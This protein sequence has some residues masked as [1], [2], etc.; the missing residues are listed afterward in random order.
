[1]DANAQ[2][3]QSPTE[4]NEPYTPT[5]YVL[6][7]GDTSPEVS[8]ATTTRPSARS[9]VPPRRDSHGTGHGGGDGD[10]A[11]T[12]REIQRT[13]AEMSQTIDALQSRLRPQHLMDEAKDAATGAL[14]DAKGALRGATVGKAE[15]MM[16]DMKYGAQDTGESLLDTIRSNPVPAA[17]AGIGLGLLFMKRGHS[18]REQHERFQGSG[19]Y[20]GLRD[21]SRYQDNRFDS[22]FERGQ[23]GRYGQPAYREYGRYGPTD[24]GSQGERGMLGQA[25]QRASQMTDQAQETAGHVADQARDTMGQVADT[26]SDFMDRTGERASDMMDTMSDRAS[27]A[28]STLWDT[29]SSNPIPVALMA[30]GAIWMWRE[31]SQSDQEEWEGHWYDYDAPGGGFER[32]FQTSDSGDT[33]SN[34]PDAGEMADQVRDQ[35]SQIG[36]QAQELAGQAQGQVYRVRGKLQRQF[37]ENPLM[38]GAAAVGVGAAIGLA[39]PSTEQEDRLMGET[40]DNL[41]HRAQDAVTDPGQIAQRV[42]SEA[43]SALMDKV[44]HPNQKD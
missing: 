3:R 28:G 4:A 12:E 24:D 5:T 15:Q 21:R 39:L 17:L 35:A 11:D 18:A 44:Q 16:S 29:V 1:M 38:V 6:K 40:R 20:R 36:D 37:Y 19:N 30:A 8:P 14:D 31:M 13:R 42:A 25:Q 41:M 33:G 43:G 9:T 23:Y 26:A 22:S 7:P 27:E 32:K 2:R 34:L 10:V